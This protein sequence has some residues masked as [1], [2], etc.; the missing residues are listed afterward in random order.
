M[1]NSE[2]RAIERC[3]SKLERTVADLKFNAAYQAR[4]M[5]EK[6]SKY[7]K[8]EEYLGYDRFLER[9]EEIHSN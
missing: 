9:W 4:P 8:N 7:E 2:K 3:L 1:L 6:D 5:T